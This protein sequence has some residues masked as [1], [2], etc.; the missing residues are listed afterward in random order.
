M[1]PRT[2]H[3]AIRDSQPGAHCKVPDA[4]TVQAAVAALEDSE[5]ADRAA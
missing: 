3:S 1:G 4:I 2:T 5:R